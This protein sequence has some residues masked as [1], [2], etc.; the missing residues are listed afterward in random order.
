MNIFSLN[1]QNHRWTLL[2]RAGLIAGIALILIQQG[3]SKK[4]NPT[5]I[6]ILPDRKEYRYCSPMYCDV[7]IRSGSGTV[8]VHPDKNIKAA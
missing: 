5:S 3:M 4:S 7:N 6:E 8:T 1:R 2:F